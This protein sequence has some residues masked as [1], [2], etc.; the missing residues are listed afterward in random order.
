MINAKNLENIEEGVGKNLKYIRVLLG[1]SQSD[2]AKILGVSYQQVQR[3][4]QG[5][6]RISPGKLF[7]L[8][9]YYKIDI[10]NF[11][12]VKKNFSTNIAETIDVTYKDL[13]LFS[14]VKAVR[15]RQQQDA[16][17]DFCYKLLNTERQS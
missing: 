5:I 4:E 13:E 12:Q 10:A 15:D 7:L 16:L 9:E 11:F 3:Y 17:K 14:L 6:N 2:V 8:S 1:R